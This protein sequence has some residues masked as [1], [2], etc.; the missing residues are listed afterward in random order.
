MRDQST[1]VQRGLQPA[2]KS[3]IR[4]GINLLRERLGG[5]PAVRG[6]TRIFTGRVCRFLWT[7]SVPVSAM[8]LTLDPWL[9]SLLRGGWE[10]QVR[11]RVRGRWLWRGVSFMG[12][13]PDRW[14]G[15]MLVAF[16]REGRRG[17]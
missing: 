5:M 12:W 6:G 7:T 1:L 10:G 17:W 11:V 16:K 4:L 9:P 3:W 8:V 13:G 14:T 2:R 15:G